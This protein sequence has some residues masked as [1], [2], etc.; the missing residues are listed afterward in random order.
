VQATQKITLKIQWYN[1]G[2]P[3]QKLWYEEGMSTS[4]RGN[5]NY[6]DE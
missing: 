6:K 3:R 4:A 5:K 2:E 1:M